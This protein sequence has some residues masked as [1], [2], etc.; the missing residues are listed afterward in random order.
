MQDA[1]ITNVVQIAAYLVYTLIG[2]LGAWLMVQVK[3]TNKAQHIQEALDATIDMAQ[4]TAMELQ[5]TVVEGL[6]AASADG[7]LSK[8]EIADLGNLLIDKTFEKLSNNTVEL[9]NST[10]VDAAAL[11]QSAGEAWI[12]SI[13]AKN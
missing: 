8:Q 2:V 13:K 7:K 3:K 11:I 1:I 12:A 6:K 5:Q 10:G 9:V 4:L